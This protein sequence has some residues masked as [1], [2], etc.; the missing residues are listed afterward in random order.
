MK[1]PNDVIIILISLSLY[2][3]YVKS[4]YYNIYLDCTLRF[5]YFLGF[6]IFILYLKKRER[7]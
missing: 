4:D 1:T 3:L 5:A 2:I 6:G 7:Y